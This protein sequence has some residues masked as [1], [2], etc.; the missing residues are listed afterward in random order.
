MGSPLWNAVWVG[1]YCPAER[2][3]EIK[4]ST[5]SENNSGKLVDAAYLAINH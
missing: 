5:K 4:S 3:S 2:R 1:I